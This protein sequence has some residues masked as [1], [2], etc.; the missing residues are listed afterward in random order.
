MAAGV[1]VASAELQSRTGD[2]RVSSDPRWSD[3]D[4]DVN[5]DVNDPIRASC[6]PPLGRR[7]GPGSNN[8]ALK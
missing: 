3:Q 4:W 8:G 5:S 2:Y 6:D 7:V 1:P